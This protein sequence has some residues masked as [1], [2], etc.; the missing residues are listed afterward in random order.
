[1]VLSDLE[2]RA[3]E[4]VYDGSVLFGQF[5]IWWYLGEKL[6]PLIGMHFHEL[7]WLHLHLLAQHRLCLQSDL[8]TRILP[9]RMALGPQT[10][11]RQR[12]LVVHPQSHLPLYQAPRPCQVGQDR[13]EPKHQAPSLEASS[14]LS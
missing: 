5:R 8:N 6:M 11:K 2:R 13:P 7:L 10:I 3:R 1:M 4:N 14:H 9:Q 12:P